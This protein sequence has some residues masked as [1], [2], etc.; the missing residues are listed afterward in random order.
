MLPHLGCGGRH[1]LRGARPLHDRGSSRYRVPSMSARGTLTSQQTNFFDTFGFIKLPGLFRDDIDEISAGFEDAVAAESARFETYEPLH[2]EKRRLIIPQVVDITPRL[3]RLRTDERVLGTVTSLLGND[4]DYAESDG[5]LL[6][7]E[8]SWHC[9][10]YGSPMGDRHV[11]LLF[12]LDPVR[13]DSGALRVI[14]GTHHFRETFARTL[15]K[16]VQDPTAIGDE[17]GVDPHDLPSVPV[18]TDPGD[19]LVCDFRTIHASFQGGMRRRLFTM[20]YRQ[21]QR[22][23]L[24]E[25]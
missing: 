19:L 7:C 3:A 10:I 8:T 25:N 18:E 23:D 20:N 4:F 15:R 24:A 6:D 1:D 5:N 13:A 2:G 14:P 17:L 12:Y 21:V 11:K 22:S 16:K 9:D